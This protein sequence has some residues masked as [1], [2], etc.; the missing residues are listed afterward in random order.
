[1]CLRI[2]Y[3]GLFISLVASS[4]FAQDSPTIAN[5]RW[6]YHNALLCN[7]PIAMLPIA[8]RVKYPQS[9]LRLRQHGRV[10]V[11]VDVDSTGRVQY[12][13]LR[14]S[15]HSAL[16]DSAATEGL[17]KMP[18]KPTISS[19]DKPVSGEIDIAVIF[20]LKYGV[21]GEPE[22]RIA[23]VPMKRDDS[24]QSVELTELEHFGGLDPNLHIELKQEAIPLQ[25]L[26][27]LVQYPDVARRAQ[28]EGKVVV[29]A[30]I[31]ADGEVV[32]VRVLHSSTYKVLDEAAQAAVKKGKFS[33]A[34]APDGSKTESWLA[35][36]I[37][38]RMD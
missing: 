18:F 7:K 11:H 16:L 22:L 23:S 34:I 35:I 20:D 9:A 13:R 28:V 31:S 17:R 33:P 14:E 27:P 3:C 29:Q 4:V 6:S 24:A 10:I 37:T 19:E 25:P 1:M 26:Q 21:R 5:T 32:R 12:V 30:L 15:S 8:A 36:P 2:A 38:F